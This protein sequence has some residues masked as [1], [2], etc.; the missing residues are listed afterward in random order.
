MITKDTVIRGLIIGGAAIA[1]AAGSRTGSKMFDRFV[2]EAVRK[3]TVA[4]ATAAALS[5]VDDEDEDE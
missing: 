1:G 4:G 2:P 5:G 3:I